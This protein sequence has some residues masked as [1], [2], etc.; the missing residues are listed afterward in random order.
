ME[1]ENNTNFQKVF[2]LILE[3]AVKG[4]L[5]ES[6][7]IKRVFVFSDMEFDQA[8]ANN[9]ETD[10]ETIHR[11]F[12]QSGYGSMVP[13]IIFWNLRDSK[14]TRV[15]ATQKGVAM[16]SGYSKNLLT[17]FLDG[18]GAVDPEATME[19]AIS[20]G[21]RNL[22]YMIKTFKMHLCLFLIHALLLGFK[23]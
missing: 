6:K 20:R 13:E 18:D 14:A 22:L 16:V 8:S 23:L 12:D 3:V 10:Y 21:T 7:M 11:K 4:K 19:R 9:W 17:I 5:S 1:W 2:D 15:M